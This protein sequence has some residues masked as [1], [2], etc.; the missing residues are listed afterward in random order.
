MVGL[1]FPCHLKPDGRGGGGGS[2]V[3]VYS[4][5]LSLELRCG[6]ESVS[7]VTRLMFMWKGQILT[8]DT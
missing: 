5:F 4:Y 7:G 1:H 6:G 8:N 2:G 3:C